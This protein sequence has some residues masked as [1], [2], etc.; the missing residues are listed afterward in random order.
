[1]NIPDPPFAP[2]NAP[3]LA[4]LAMV[5]LLVGVPNT[6]DTPVTELETVTVLFTVRAP[7]NK[8]GLELVEF[9]K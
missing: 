6:L 9:M 5:K 7:V 8:L 3:L 2:N 1:M 4:L